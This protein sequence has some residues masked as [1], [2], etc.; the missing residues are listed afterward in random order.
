[1]NRF[2]CLATN[3]D[4]SFNN[5]EWSDC[6]SP[7]NGSCIY[8]VNSSST[9]TINTCS[10]TECIAEA[11][12]GGAVYVYAI[13]KA[14]ITESSFVHCKILSAS[15]QEYG[16]G[17]IY[18]ELVSDEVLIRLCSFLDSSVPYDGA[19]VDMWSCSCTTCNTKTFQDCTFIMCKGKAENSFPYNELIEE[20]GGILAWSN[21]YNVGISNALFSE[22]FNSRGGALQL[23]VPLEF[24]SPF[25]TFCLF[26]EN[27]ASEDGRDVF[28]RNCNTNPFSHSFTTNPDNDRVYTVE[29]I[30]NHY[31]NWLPHN[32]NENAVLER[33]CQYH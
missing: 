9:L 24:S 2:E 32:F 29:N 13:N 19:G 3:C 25:I 15:Y 10:Y 8:L 6:K 5:C 12:C 18:L 26:H 27:D 14:T 33:V 31:P 28:F 21:R 11:D 1:M 16:G 20:G 22:C 17:C 30:N 23:Y 4:Y 7:S